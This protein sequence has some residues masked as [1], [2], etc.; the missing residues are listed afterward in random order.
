MLIS[1]VVFS[2]RLLWHDIGH[3]FDSLLFA[4]FYAIIHEVL[5]LDLDLG[6]QVQVLTSPTNVN[7]TQFE[8][9]NR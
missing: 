3:Q 6:S 5:D 8:K 9:E 7:V 4:E 1:V 2:Q